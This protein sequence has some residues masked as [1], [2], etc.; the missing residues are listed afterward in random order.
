MRLAV[1]DP[2][3]RVRGYRYRRPRRRHAGRRTLLPAERIRICEEYMAGY[4]I[5]LIVE[6]WELNDARSLR[7]IVLK[8]LSETARKVRLMAFAGDQ[9]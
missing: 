1:S 9:E 6:R 7:A 3:P 4:N 2:V 8:V 5:D